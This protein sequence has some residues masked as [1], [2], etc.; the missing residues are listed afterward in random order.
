MYVNVRI[1]DLGRVGV[2]MLCVS[3]R[4]QCESGVD[5]GVNVTMLSE[6]L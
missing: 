5:A 4:E 1:V 3:D 6:T 2:C